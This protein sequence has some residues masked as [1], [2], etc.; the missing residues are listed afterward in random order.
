MGYGDFVSETLQFCFKG[1]GG[2]LYKKMLKL[3]IS[4]K[5]ENTKLLKKISKKIKIFISLLN[6]L[7]NFDLLQ[8]LH[9]IEFPKEESVMSTD[10][11]NIFNEDKD[12]N[13]ESLL[14]N[15]VKRLKLFD[16]Y[17]KG[18]ILTLLGNMCQIGELTIYTNQEKIFVSFINNRPIIFSDLLKLKQ[19]N[20]DTILVEKRE[21]IDNEYEFRYIEG[22]F[23]VKNFSN[24]KKPSL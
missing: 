24:I 22:S 21:K 6:L 23:R 5:C 12:K 3:K 16:P 13:T 1:K 10:N 20:E 18:D 14:Q 17:T 7:G 9:N 8:N 2:I 4:I 11:A 15:L 19:E